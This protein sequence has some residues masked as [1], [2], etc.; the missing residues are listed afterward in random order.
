MRAHVDRKHVQA[1]LSLASPVL[2]DM[3]EAEGDKSNKI[4]VR[5]RGFE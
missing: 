4:K 5:A 3:L 1:L 2:K